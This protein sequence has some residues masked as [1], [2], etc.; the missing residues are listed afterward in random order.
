MENKNKAHDCLRL[1]KI[2]EQSKKGEILMLD[3]VLKTTG[4]ASLE[5]WYQNSHSATKYLEKAFISPMY[6]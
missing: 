6:L 2:K 4:Y 3:K 1:H 5:K